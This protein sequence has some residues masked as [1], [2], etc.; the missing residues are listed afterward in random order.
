MFI[1]EK[2]ENADMPP[3]PT[4]HLILFKYKDSVAHID[5]YIIIELMLYMLLMTSFSLALYLTAS[6]NA[7]LL[8]LYF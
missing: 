5:V 8:Y 1:K 3:N 2:L 6:E 7:H 4:T